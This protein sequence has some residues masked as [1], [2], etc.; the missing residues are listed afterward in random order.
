ME[1]SRR[2]DCLLTSFIEHP[3]AGELTSITEAVKDAKA[4]LAD[5]KAAAAR[6][7]TGVG[8]LA[9]AIKQVTAVTEEV[10]AAHKELKDDLAGISNFNPS[11]GSQNSGGG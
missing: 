2:L 10:E 11:N 8:R 1:K 5:A 7:T 4:A 9:D 6:L 3:M